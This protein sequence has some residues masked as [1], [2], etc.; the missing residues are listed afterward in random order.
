MSLRILGGSLKGREL[1]M[2]AG[3]TL[4]PT[5]SVMRKALFDICSFHIEEAHV[6]DVFAGS[7]SIGIEALSRGATHVTFIEKERKTVQVLLQ[8]LI[9]LEMQGKATVLCGDVFLQVKKLSSSFDLI[10]IDPPY[11]LVERADKPIEAL[12]HFFDESSLLHKGAMIFLE[13]RA[14]GCF[15]KDSFIAKRLL[16]KSSRR[17]GSS[18]LHQWIC[19]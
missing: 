13:E 6:L 2:P 16:W 15:S 1:K 7:G 18:I 11:P 10:Y 19:S 4:R 8:N 14:P 3:A 12:M 5:M 9:N 17:F